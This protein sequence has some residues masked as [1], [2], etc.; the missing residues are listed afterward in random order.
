MMPAID[1]TENSVKYKG[2]WVAMEEDQKTVIASGETLRETREKAQ[3]IGYKRP[4][5]FHVP[6]EIVPQIG[7]VL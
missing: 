5:F 4:I 7:L 3:K 1:W 6:S 2:L